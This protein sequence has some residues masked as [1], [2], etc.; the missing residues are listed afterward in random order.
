MAAQASEASEIR[1]QIERLQRRLEELEPGQGAAPPVSPMPSRGGMLVGDETDG[2]TE[3]ER[4]VERQLRRLD[5]RV[6]ALE[7]GMAGRA[8]GPL[9]ELVSAAIGRQRDWADPLAEAC[10]Q[11][12]RMMLDAGGPPARTVLKIL[13]GRPWFGHPLH[14]ALTDVPLGA[15]LTAMALDLAGARRGAD[16]AI[17]LGL[18]GVMPTMMTGCADFRHTE[19]EARRVAFVHML[20]TCA[21]MQLYLLSLGARVVGRRGLGVG[22]STAGLAIVSGAAYLGGELVF[23]FGTRVVPAT[24]A[25]TPAES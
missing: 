8:A 10:Q 24:A 21:A 20:L 15:W 4:H 19:G 11:G 23:T 18:L 9:A 7:A 16:T 25:S 6:G 5:E 22:L 12:L 3:P 13:D 14:P 17:A 1:R 2:Q